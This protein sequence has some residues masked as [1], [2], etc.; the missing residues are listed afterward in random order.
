MAGVNDNLIPP[1]K[2]EVRNPKGKPKGTKHLS[3]LIRNIGDDIDWNKTT[4]KDREAMQKR[5]GKNAWEAITY[6]AFTKAMSGDDKAMRWLADNG[7][8]K[9][10]DITTDGEKL[11]S[12]AL[13]EF[14]DEPSQ[15]TDTD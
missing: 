8:G 14:I 13:V 6:V 1:K 4:L 10:L 11:N 3:T 5:Y 15:D 7:F 12:V 2:G 9:H